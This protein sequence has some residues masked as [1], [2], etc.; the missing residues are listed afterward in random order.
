VGFTEIKAEFCGSTGV[1]ASRNSSR[2]IAF[3]HVKGH[4]IAA[5]DTRIL[6]INLG[7][8]AHRAMWG[9]GVD[10]PSDTGFSQVT[11][12]REVPGPGRD[13]ALMLPGLMTPP[14]R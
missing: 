4:K 5:E 1:R 10:P 8:V 2:Q 13:A 3:L 7:A 6:E 12:L 9:Y 14:Q 11:A